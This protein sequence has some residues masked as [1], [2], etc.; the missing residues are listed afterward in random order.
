M[1]TALAMGALGA[2]ILGEYDFTWSTAIVSGLLFGLFLAE[3]VVTVGRERGYAWS[4]MAAA[5]TAAGLVWAGWISIRR[6]GESVPTPAW[7]AAAI[8]AVSAAIRC[9]PVPAPAPDTSTER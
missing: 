2:L 9:R 1:A 3:A 5:C 4:A 8:G 6:T 7:V